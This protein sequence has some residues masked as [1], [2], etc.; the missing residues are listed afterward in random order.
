MERIYRLGSLTPYFAFFRYFCF[1]GSLFPQ[2]LPPSLLLLLLLLLLFLFLL[3][4]LV[5]LVFLF[6][7]SRFANMP[8][9]AGPGRGS[10]CSFLSPQS[11]E[12]RNVQYTLRLA[13]AAGNLD[14]S[15]LDA[16]SMLNPR[17]QLKF[18][19][20]SSGLTHVYGWVDVNGYSDQDIDQI[21]N[22][23]LYAS[24]A[25]PRRVIVGALQPKEAYPPLKGHKQYLYCKVAV[26]RSY[27]V[28]EHE[29]DDTPIPA[30]FHSNYLCG[31]STAFP[32]VSALGSAMSADS[33]T[34]RRRSSGDGS[35]FN[36]DE[37]GEEVATIDNFH[38]QYV[39]ASPAQLMPLYF[40]CF[41]VIKS[42]I[43]DGKRTCQLCEDA[44]AVLHCEKCDA[45][46]C[47]SCDAD[48]HHMNK[49]LK[50][51]LRQPMTSIR[52]TQSVGE[53]LRAIKQRLGAEY[54][55]LSTCPIHTSQKVEF[56][57]PVLDVPVC[58]HCKM[59]G[60]HSS[61]AAV[62]HRL[63]GIEDAYE[64]ALRESMTPDSVLAKRRE[65]LQR[66]KDYI[67]DIG[68]SVKANA[69]ATE[70]EIYAILQAALQTN[71]ALAQRKLRILQSVEVDLLREMFSL[72]WMECFLRD[73][74]D[75]LPPAAFLKL[76]S[77]HMQLRETQYDFTY[78]P[79]ESLVS[80]KPDIVVQ[81][82]ITVSAGDDSHVPLRREKVDHDELLDGAGRRSPMTRRFVNIL[83]DE[84]V[85]VAAEPGWEYDRGNDGGLLGRDGEDVQL[86][87]QERVLSFAGADPQEMES[88]Q[89][90][91]DDARRGLHRSLQRAASV[92]EVYDSVAAAVGEFDSVGNENKDDGSI[93]SGHVGRLF[94]VVIQPQYR[95][96]E[97]AAKRVQT[98]PAFL[99]SL[100]ATGNFSFDGSKILD[101]HK[102]TELALCLPMAVD[103]GDVNLRSIR[104]YDSDDHG[105]SVE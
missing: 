35:G 66:S 69:A 48:T 80:I 28:K 54:S 85:G 47:E 90:K 22:D 4:L 39:V 86:A 89:R 37:G 5:V 13:L 18:N 45:V 10:N 43:A 9:V 34:A 71:A 92:P 53:R 52:E 65:Q 102:A 64:K 70:K 99:D 79:P 20:H 96:A 24:A 14:L 61:G 33:P 95:M 29:T 77:Q 3:L 98:S 27:P 12:F 16:W 31:N 15:E 32:A 1:F 7:L 30:G 103:G 36:G 40:V 8:G 94:D 62:N 56:Y 84:K 6:H 46:F 19:N 91:A 72:E 42:K 67:A 88:F 68:R 41:S 83:L 104:L 74:R 81:G 73:Q 21:F 100:S 76:W 87:S 82:G 101:N 97:I 25:E 44:P 105:K 75:A 93:S 50:R 57:D 63:V 59:V 23:G 60:S 78:R 17:Q 2:H 58:V 26:G 38:H 11:P 49:L 55:A 51:H